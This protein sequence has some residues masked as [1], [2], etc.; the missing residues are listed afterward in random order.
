MELTKLKTAN[1]I[2]PIAAA[3]FW[4]TPGLAQ[5][6]TMETVVEGI[7]ANATAP[8]HID[9][10][11]LEFFPNIT[12]EAGNFTGVGKAFTFTFT[13]DST[14]AQQYDYDRP[15]GDPLSGGR[16][17][18][19][20][21]TDENAPNSVIKS[22]ILTVNGQSLNFSTPNF[23]TINQYVDDNSQ[24]YLMRFGGT[25]DPGSTIYFKGAGLDPLP[26]SIFDVFSDK[27][28]TKGFPSYGYVSLLSNGLKTEFGFDISSIAV[29]VLNGT[30]TGPS[31]GPSPGPQ[32]GTGGG[33]G[34]DL[35][36]GSGTGG[37]AADVPLP[38][39]LPLLLSAI[40][41]VFALGRRRSKSAAR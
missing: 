20:V 6:A 18:E 12:G 14:L 32:P 25:F 17:V 9:S 2:A 38:A 31:V 4:L 13:W 29:S 22:S 11:G 40:G 5:A 19:G 16:Q 7:I 3:M 39:A 37:G 27:T 34:I 24:E 21:S 30:A 36:G 15:F 33:T 26:G 35:G 23:F 28:I 41:G 10:D 1:R 8:D